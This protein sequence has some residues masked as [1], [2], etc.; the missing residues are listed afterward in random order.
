MFDVPVD[1]VYVWVGVASVSVVALGV[2]VGLPSAAPPNATNAAQAVDAVAVGPPGSQG[3]HEL[4]ANRIRLGSVRIGLAGPG[5][6]SHATF[7]YAPVTPVPGESRLAR[8][9]AGERPGSVFE[10][11]G[12]FSDAVVDQRRTDPEW[13]PA[14]DRLDVRRVS[15]RGVD[16]TLVG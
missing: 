4:A 5:G 1:A 13:R 10:S 3:S 6:K 7:G 14:P 12:R 9:L 16:A 2:V 8:V 15:W 11:S